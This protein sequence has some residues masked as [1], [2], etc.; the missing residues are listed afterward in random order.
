[1]VDAPSVE[2]F[3]VSL[4]EALI[5]LMQL[6]MALLIA[7]SVGHNDL[8]KSLP[9]Q[10]VRLFYDSMICDKLWQSYEVPSN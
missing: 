8:Q 9:T 5:S 2:I 4:D 10:T 6:K 7:V 3:K 1:M